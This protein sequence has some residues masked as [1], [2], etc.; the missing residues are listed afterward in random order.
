MFHPLG[1]PKSDESLAMEIGIG[2]VSYAKQRK[3]LFRNRFPN[4]GRQRAAN[5]VI[6]TWQR[7][8]EDHYPAVIF[9]ETHAA[10]IF[11]HGI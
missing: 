9:G 8:T 5:A 2:W 6:E 11:E 3:F 7:E 4:R 10:S 1:L